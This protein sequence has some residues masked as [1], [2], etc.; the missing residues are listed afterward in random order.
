MNYFHKTIHSITFLTVLLFPFAL[1]FELITSFRRV[2]PIHPY[3]AKFR[4]LGVGNLT[5]GGTGK[6]PMVLHLAQLLQKDNKIA[7]VLRGYK[8][9]YEN[10]NELISNYDE[11]FPH[12]AK[13][14][15]EAFLYT[16]NLPG[17][18]VCV[19]KDRLAS[20]RLLEEKFPD[21]DYVI[22][23]DAFQYLKI[24]QD[25]QYCILKSNHPLG[26]GLC[27]PAGILREPFRNLRFADRIV[28]YGD[29]ENFPPHLL[30]HIKQWN[31]PLFYCDNMID[32]IHD[33][34]NRDFPIE[35][36]YPKKILLLSGIGSPSSF[37][38]TV[39]KAGLVFSDHFIVKDH[40]PYSANFF[41][42]HEEV[43]QQYDY[44]LI[45]EKDYCKIKQYTT[46]LPFLVVK[47]MLKFFPGDIL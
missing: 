23:D 26:N 1:L 36:L 47:I 8:G 11:V 30:K 2:L 7:I 10:R 24:K 16:Q 21:L 42:A 46:C 3:Q 4:I 31:K 19:G 20:V 34:Q 45:T 25:L 13:A 27:L 17:V 22:F 5:V 39:S 38:R 33:C 9:E 37:E 41:Q 12:A 29:R 44:I 40:F 15:D 32:K 35:N 14:G 28:I 18:P 43:F 6:T